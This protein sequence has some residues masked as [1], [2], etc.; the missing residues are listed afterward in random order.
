MTLL[1]DTQVW[2]WM[3]AEPRRL[4]GPARQL[5]EDV[6]TPLFLSAASSWEIAIKHEIGRLQ[7]PEVPDRYVP[8]RIRMIGA[9]AL[10]I[11]H[12]HAL[13]VVWVN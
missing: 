4:S 11:E 9:R 2:L 12:S 5:V 8:S 6:R 13:A 3:L 7:L 1:L 10:P